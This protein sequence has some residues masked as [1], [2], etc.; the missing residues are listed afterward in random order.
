MLLFMGNPEYSCWKL[1]NVLRQYNY[2]SFVFLFRVSNQ[3][4]RKSF[5]LDINL[6]SLLNFT[7]G[8]SEHPYIFHNS[9]SSKLKKKQLPNPKIVQQAHTQT[10]S[11]VH[12]PTLTS[13]LLQSSQPSTDVRLAA[14]FD[15][16]LHSTSDETMK[17]PTSGAT[18]HPPSSQP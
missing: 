11:A 4:G 2:R 7:N 12:F 15:D 1:L 17:P 8:F 14:N 3:F 13:I 16:P 5:T 10:L 9:I 6:V 18:T